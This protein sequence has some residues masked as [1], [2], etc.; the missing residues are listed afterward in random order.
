MDIKME[1]VMDVA[2]QYHCTILR[3]LC[4]ECGTPL[5]KFPGQVIA[6]CIMRIIKNEYAQQDRAVLVKAMERAGT[7]AFMSSTQTHGNVTIRHIGN[8]AFVEVKESVW[9]PRTLSR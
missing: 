2:A 1:L 3:D 6:L 7:L 4:P 9:E 8:Q 5:V